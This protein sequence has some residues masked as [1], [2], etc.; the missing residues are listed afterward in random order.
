MPPPKNA[1]PKVATADQLAAIR[2]K[3]REARDLKVVINNLEEQIKEKKLDQNTIEHET[4]PEMFTKA[5]IDNL[6][7]PAE[8][9]LP[10]Y[11]AK[12]K[13]YYHANIAAEWP[14]EKRQEAF[15]YLIKNKHGDLIKT[16][17]TILLGRGDH[18]LLVKIK[19]LLKPLKLD[20]TVDLSVPWNTLTAFVKEQIEDK[21]VILKLDLLGAQVGQVVSLKQRKDD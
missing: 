12:L 16:A 2:D 13:P 10:A 3:M 21:K 11:D 19:K 8:G 1:K 5:G 14:P 17:V 18:A 4:L 6:G 9:N 15:D 7:L 20:V